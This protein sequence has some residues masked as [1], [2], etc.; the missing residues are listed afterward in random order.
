MR[1]SSIRLVAIHGLFRA[2]AIAGTSCFSE[3]LC[4]RNVAGATQAGAFSMANPALPARSFVR[5]KSAP[6]LP[7]R[8]FKFFASFAAGK[9]SSMI[10]VFP[11]T[12][13]LE[14]DFANPLRRFGEQLEEWL[15]NFAR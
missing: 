11:L 2:G 14:K 1:S 12:L 3:L 7:E 5:P 9:L 4:N 13:A 10:Q 6:V 8:S 15:G